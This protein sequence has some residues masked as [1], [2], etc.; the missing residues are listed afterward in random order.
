MTLNKDMAIPATVADLIEARDQAVSKMLASRKLMEEAKKILE[1][2][3]PYMFPLEC[4]FEN[5][6]D[7][8]LTALDRR[9]WLRSFDITG[10][11][12]LM[13]TKAVEE[14]NRDLD[15]NTPEFNEGNIRATF[16]SLHQ[17]AHGMFRRGIVNVFRF[18][19]DGYRTNSKEPF[20]IGDKVICDYMT[21]AWHGPLRV[22]YHNTASNRL[23]DIDRV[24]K[25]LDDQKFTP[26]A[27]EA[28]INAAWKDG[29]TL[30]EDEYFKIRGFKKGTMHI[31]FKRTDLLERVNELVAEE[32]GENKLA[33]RSAA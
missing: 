26:R 2:T 5:S 19:S 3:G 9:M 13:D 10:F 18:L 1:T 31:W 27:L 20:R 28:A 4:H 15:K 25:A 6:H 11:R 30:Y 29:D 7:R 8:A 33:Q 23:D 16:L 32:Y 24:F 17:E 22:N 21:T 12:Q 14:F